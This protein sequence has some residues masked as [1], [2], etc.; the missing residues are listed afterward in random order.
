MLIFRKRSASYTDS[1]VEFAFWI[2]I[3]DF[4]APIVR[5]FAYCYHVVWLVPPKCSLVSA[6]L[7]DVTSQKTPTFMNYSLPWE[8][9][10]L[11]TCYRT[12][13]KLLARIASIAE[14]M[15]NAEETRRVKTRSAHCSHAKTVNVAALT[16]RACKYRV[17]LWCCKQNW[18]VGCRLPTLVTRLFRWPC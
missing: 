3:A 2:N 7:Q 11:D 16:N 15:I 4:T 5:V 1:R 12:R 13:N 9:E 18:R 8:G 6:D 10:F 14:V 17:A